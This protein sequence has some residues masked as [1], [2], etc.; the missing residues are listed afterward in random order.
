[1][2]GKTNSCAGGVS[3]DTLTAINKTREPIF[4]GDKVWINK[5]VQIGGTNFYIGK[6]TPT[7]YGGYID[8]VGTWGWADNIMYSL[9]SDSATQTGTTT[10]NN[11]NS[12][13]IKYGA[14]GSIFIM[15]YSNNYAVRCDANARYSISS[16]YFVGDKYIAISNDS[17]FAI[18]ILDLTTGV[19]VKT[20]NS[21][22]S[23]LDAPNDYATLG[24]LPDGTHCFYTIQNGTMTRFLI[25]EENDALTYIRFKV[26][27]TTSSFM[28]IACTLDGKYIIGKSANK[29]RII[30][31]NGDSAKLLAQT[32][33][34]EDLQ[35]FYS[36]NCAIT[37][38]P[39]TEVLTL[40]SL[41]TSGNYIYEYAIVK[42]S[43][44][45]G[46]EKLP[47]VFPEDYNF[48]SYITVSDDLSRC[49]IG[50]NNTTRSRII[51]LETVSGYSTVSYKS[52]HINKNTLTGKA[53]TSAEIGEAMTVTT[54][55]PE[56]VN[57]EVSVG[58][59]NIELTME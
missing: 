18:S 2:L 10:D 20:Y 33:M 38:N 28:L 55:L 59:D 54:I 46:F 45:N 50:G 14:E 30:E 32:E 7:S 22:L 17:K 9:D 16:R 31:I 23:T 58:N 13:Y 25:D 27:N 52:H 24:Y 4:Q 48:V 53:V 39:Y 21:D 34:P 29:L 56:M 51:N 15:G 47:V 8:R 36:L 3:G 12:H 11:A 1:M 43:A 5:D 41:E 6:S 37:F 49:C 19:S 35:L 57:V 40:A 44:E 42:Y 26:Q